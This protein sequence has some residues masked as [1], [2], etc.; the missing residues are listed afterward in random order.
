VRCQQQGAGRS[1][2]DDADFA[3]AAFD[4]TLRGFE[5]ENHAARN[6]AALDQAFNL[7]AGDDRE[8]SLP[9]ENA[10]DV[11]E[12]DQLIS[13]EIFRAGGGH[14]VGVDVVQLIVRTQAEAR[15]NG[16]KPFVPERFDEGRVQ[17]GEIA[18]EAQTAFDF[19][20]HH[21]LG[22]E[23][24]SVRGRDA[25]GGLP[26]RG[27]RRGQ[28]LIQQA[29]E[30]HDGHIARFAVGDAQA[31][32][33]L[34]FDGHALEGGGEKAAAAMHDENFVAL[35]GKRRDLLR[36]RAHRVVVFQQCSCELDYD[37]H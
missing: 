21:G 31:G 33:E 1:A 3:D 26:F 30:Y 15:G 18:D 2:A 12:I 34:A 20:V 7:L 17:S 23:T 35:L 28:F 24:P 8:N 11:R 29:G 32:D 16:Q 22:D 27:D 10:G 25:D 6:D 19:V 36:E 13:A 5:L 14:V 37:S 4:G 9:I